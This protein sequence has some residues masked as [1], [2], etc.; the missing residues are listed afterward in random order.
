MRSSLDCIPCFVRQALDA[1]RAVSDDPAIHDDVVREILQW[2]A[3]AD[4]SQSPPSFAQHIHRRLR[5]ITRNGDPYR[6][7]KDRQN[8]MALRLLPGLRAVV[9]GADDPLE[10][11]VR[12]AI[13]GNAIDMGV[14][15]EVTEADLG[16]AV[17]QALEQPL[18]GDYTGFRRAVESA[19]SILYLADNAGEIALD[20]LLV[21]QLGRSR[22]TVAVRGVPVL[23]DATLVDAH[24][25]GLDE[26]VEVIDNGSDAPGTILSDCSEEFRRRFAAAD[27]VLAKGQ[28]NYESLND[29]PRDIFFLFKAKCQVIAGQ[30]G[31]PVGA[32]VIVR[33]PCGAVTSREDR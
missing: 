20:R 7:A 25:V 27:L 23:N 28:G 30:V 12:L 9:D 29:E 24:A 10:R 4:L 31:M 18:A 32:H 6:A 21:E 14:E 5:T 11:A 3:D 15:A 2:M 13:A 19:G 33:T 26:M 22:V 16:R 1:V 8:Q 17:E